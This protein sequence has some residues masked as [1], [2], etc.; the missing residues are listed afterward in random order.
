MVVTTVRV[1][2]VST[3]QRLLNTLLLKRQAPHTQSGP[4]PGVAVGTGGLGDWTLSRPWPGPSLGRQI[5]GAIQG[6][7]E[8]HPR[9]QMAR[10]PRNQQ[11]PRQGPARRVEA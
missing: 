7:R 8:P 2:Q 11:R 5:S 6:A 10:C 4:A 9:E 1:P 3:G